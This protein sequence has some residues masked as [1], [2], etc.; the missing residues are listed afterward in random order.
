MK[1]IEY[2]WH[3]ITHGK[4]ILFS[5]EIVCKFI[6][7]DKQLKH[8][9]MFFS[10]CSFAQGLRISSENNTLY[11]LSLLTN[12]LLRYFHAISQLNHESS[13]PWKFKDNNKYIPKID[14]HSL[15]TKACINGILP[16]GIMGTGTSM[17][18]QHN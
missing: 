11:Q 16:V 8:T 5:V 3:L 15:T 12:V 2:T 9:N 14:L 4:K 7:T 10:S 1:L 6:L 13:R 17:V 18:T